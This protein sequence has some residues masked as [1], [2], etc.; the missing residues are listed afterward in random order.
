[1]SRVSFLLVLVLAAGCVRRQES[2]PE[3]G[4]R[5]ATRDWPTALAAAQ[6][7]ALERRF[8]DAD[9]E[10]ELYAQRNPGTPQARESSYWRALFRID[11]AN[12]GGDARA[13][14]DQIDRY[15]A[16][17][18]SYSP[19][20]AEALTLRRLAITLDSLD[21]ASGELAMT[22]AR[23]EEGAAAAATARERE[24]EL[25]RQNQQLKEQ[26]EKT[27]AELERIKKRLGG[28]P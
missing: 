15:L 10:M 28:Q 16:D 12:D 21:R 5:W 22:T 25:V 1:M 8:A 11:P 27:T 26:L 6:A 14:L 13:A 18:V 2:A 24:T 20:R 3:P 7:A 19:R 17:S 4:V 23:S 9:R